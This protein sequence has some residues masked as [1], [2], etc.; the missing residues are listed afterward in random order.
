MRV[1]AIGKIDAETSHVFI[2]LSARAS[3]AVEV[4]G[5][6]A[7][8][9]CRPIGPAEQWHALPFTTQDEAEELATAA[10]HRIAPRV[11]VGGA[12]ALGSDERA[13]LAGFPLQVQS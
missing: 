1:S 5:P 4:S 7:N 11:C 12:L 8:L 9:R 6:P 3:V 2:E 13:P 10:H